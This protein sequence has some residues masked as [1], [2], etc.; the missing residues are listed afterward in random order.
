MNLLDTPPSIQLEEFLKLYSAYQSINI[1]QARKLIKETILYY[2]S[3][4]TKR[5]ELRHIQEMENKWYQSLD[6]DPRKPDY[7]VYDHKYYFTDLWACWVIYSRTYLKNI[8]KHVVPA[9][10]NPTSVLDLGCGIG[11][12]TAAL[13][14]MFPGAWVY[15]TNIETSRQFGFCKEM[16]DRWD[17]AMLPSHRHCKGLVDVVFASEY[18]EHIENPLVELAGVLLLNPKWL[19]IANAFNTVSIGH[20]RVYCEGTIHQGAISKV[21]DQVLIDAGYEKQK[22]GL[23]NNRPTIWKKS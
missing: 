10:G 21:F 2:K 23:W 16:G 15:G 14:E 8:R 12:T 6:I 20:F 11:F 22:M 4:G 18:F 5:G 19:I 1:D 7:D 17:F 3:P 9:M 13:S